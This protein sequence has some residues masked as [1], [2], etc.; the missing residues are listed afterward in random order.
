MDDD[1]WC[2]EECT[3]KILSKHCRWNVEE[4]W[5]CVCVFA[6]DFVSGATISIEKFAYPSALLTRSR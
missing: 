3:V 1:L 2:H 6:N 4:S 5:I